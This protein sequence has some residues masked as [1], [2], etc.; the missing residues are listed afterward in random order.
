MEDANRGNETFHFDTMKGHVKDYINNR[1]E[2]FKL[3]VIEYIAR[4]MP[5]IVFVVIMGIL[6]I[7]F[8]IFV[9]IAVAMAIGNSINSQVGGF[10]IVSGIN[11]VLAAIFTLAYKKIIFKPVS[12]FT[13]KVLI[14]SLEADE[15]Q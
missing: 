8:W 5:V 7:L 10:L 13:V 15:N 4:L 14:K 1:L 2:Y 6:I 9:N 3:V 12:S 11:L